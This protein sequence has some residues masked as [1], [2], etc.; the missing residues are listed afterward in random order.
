MITVYHNQQFMESYLR[1]FMSIEPT[2]Y[3]DAQQLVP[4]A[5][6]DT[7]DLGTAFDLIQH[8]RQP[9]QKHPQV[10][11]LQPSRSTA[12][13]DIL[14]K[15]DGTCWIVKIEGFKLLEGLEPPTVKPC[16]HNA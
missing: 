3:V 4:V 6:A 5:I 12:V 2:F 10:R 9:W 11:C 15:D 7:D 1:Q 14:R 16:L 13:G 8:L